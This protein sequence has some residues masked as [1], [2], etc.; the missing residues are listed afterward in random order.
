MS[1]FCLTSAV[2]IGNLLATYAA[3]GTAEEYTRFIPLVG[4][5][6]AGSL[7]FSTTYFLLDKWLNELEETALKILDET[8][9]IRHAVGLPEK[10]EFLKGQLE[11]RKDVETKIGE[12]D[13]SGVGKSSFLTAIRR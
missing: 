9:K 3:S 1:R 12:A 8:R 11:E 2:Q 13:G 4:T 5:F 10:E 7:S 6:I